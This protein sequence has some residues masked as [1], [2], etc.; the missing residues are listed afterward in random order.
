M[1]RSPTAIDEFPYPTA[2]DEFPRIIEQNEN[3]A[4][5]EKFYYLR[6]LLQG[7]A[8]SAVEG[9]TLNENNYM[10]VLGLLK[11]R[12]G[13]EKLLQATFIDSLFIFLCHVS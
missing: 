9:L 7:N 10:E 13:D 11:T 5:I 1:I 8:K 6:G 4:Q 3:L 12:F 2:I